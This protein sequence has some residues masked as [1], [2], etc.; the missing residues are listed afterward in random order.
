MTKRVHLFTSS[1]C[2]PCKLAKRFFKAKDIEFEEINIETLPS[3][4]AE[5]F[6][7]PTIICK[8]EDKEDYTFEGFSVGVG[9][10]ILKWYKD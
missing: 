8:T 10:K 2:A 9:N 6:S 1:S 7:I 5:I 3:H 4:V